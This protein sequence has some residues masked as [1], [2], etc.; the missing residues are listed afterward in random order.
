M[1]HHLQPPF[2]WGWG[3]GFS[4][5]SGGA[6]DPDP[7]SASHSVHRASQTPESHGPE[8]GSGKGTWTK[9]A[10]QSASLEFPGAEEDRTGFVFNSEHENQS[11]LPSQA[12]RDSAFP[13]TLL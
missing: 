10:N 8:T 1:Q 3:G 2:L 13:L 7:F 4:S 6:G 12:S 5:G 11:Q 9:V